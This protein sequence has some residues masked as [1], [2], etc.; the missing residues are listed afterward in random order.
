MNMPLN[1]LLSFFYKNY[2]YIF[3]F[4]CLNS[5]LF[6]QVKE[7]SVSDEGITWENSINKGY[8]KKSVAT[9]KKPGFA[10]KSTM[11]S[12][13]ILLKINDSIYQT[14]HVLFLIPSTNVV[15]WPDYQ[16]IFGDDNN[17]FGNKK[18][19][20]Y[21][22]PILK[23]LIPFNF[24]AVVLISD[25]ASPNYVPNY[26]FR[27]LKA[28]GINQNA[29]NYDD[30][31][32]CRYNIGGKRTNNVSINVLD[33]EMGHGWGVF[34]YPN[35]VGHWPYNSTV[36]CSMSDHW[37]DTR[38][39][40]IIPKGDPVNGFFWKEIRF[41]Q[42]I[43]FSLQQ[44]YLMGLQPD[45]PVAYLIN[46]PIF[47]PDSSISYTSYEKLDYNLII[48]NYGPRIPDYRTSQKKL[49]VGFIFV[50]PNLQAIEERYSDLE[51]EIIYY[52]YATE[53]ENN[54]FSSYYHETVP[55]NV[56]THNRASIDSKLADLDGNNSP[57]IF[58]PE[59][60]IKI[61]PGESAKI[62]FIASDIEDGM[63]EITCLPSDG[64]VTIGTSSLIFNSGSAE[65]TF[66]YT[67]KATDSGGKVC[68]EHFVVDVKPC[69]HTLNTLERS[70]I[71]GD[72]ILLG[73][74][75]RKNEGTYYDYY[76]TE[77]GCDSIIATELTIKPY[78]GILANFPLSS[79]GNDVTGINDPMTIT[80]A[81]FQEEGIY[82]NGIYTE[83]IAITPPIHEFDF[84]SFTIS[85]DFMVNENRQQ[86]VI[87]G[88]SG[89]RWLGFYLNADGTVSLLYN[90]NYYLQSTKTYTLN[91]WHNAQISYD[92]TTAKMYI[93]SM[94]AC[95]VNIQLDYAACGSS[96]T[97]IGIINSSNGQVFKGYIKNL[98]VYNT[99]IS[100]FLYLSRNKLNITS[101]KNNVD[102]FDIIS[103]TNWN[104]A[105][106]QPWLTFSNKTGM[107]NETISVYAITN[108][109]INPRFA[110]INVSGDEFVQKAIIVEQ[111]GT[112]PE[113]NVSP[114][115]ISVESSSGNVSITITSNVDWSFS[116]S[117]N[118]LQASKTNDSTLS[119][120]YDENTSTDIRSAI[121]T[122]IASDVL[123]H[124]A[125]IKQN[126]ADAV[127]NIR[128]DSQTVASSGGIT[129]FI[130]RSNINWTATENSDWLTVNKT[131]DS[132]LQVTYDENTGIVTRYTEITILGTGIS[133]QV[134]KVIQD[135]TT[136][137]AIVDVF[138]NSILTIY[139]NPAYSKI[140]IKPN[141]E[142]NK[143]IRIS[144]YDKTGKII[145]S[146]KINKLFANVPVEIDVSD[147][148]SGVYI[149]HISSDSTNNYKKI[150][151]K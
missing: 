59:K 115:N 81:P 148:P 15:K 119:V 29:I 110:T 140:Y 141:S 30:I 132:T 36:D 77:E 37:D 49:K 38:G 121:V 79:N 8:S 94:L 31:D 145:Y 73:G 17:A 130:I 144:L 98:K 22:I 19:D 21:Y 3:L 66:F 118:W 126:G 48:E 69:E 14:E 136:V 63:P 11:N 114:E 16:S 111:E 60:Y 112:I 42:R 102:T 149:L 45:F 12:E 104:I 47:N 84:N 103:N 5:S 40:E 10:L 86:P 52:S 142:I 43:E 101:S 135:G 123:T 23:N 7:S 74:K 91:K 147:L 20:S 44:L 105:S 82:C 107:N 24:D 85:A 116:E 137:N 1:K 35:D 70:I 67:I 128:P 125:I 4:S 27:K 122:L 32:I 99:F 53:K 50:A 34:V 58:L 6:S 113:L 39:S 139:P 129:K 18:F 134:V 9:L 131:N 120:T 143:K 109:S 96:D 41:R 33:H 51:K 133:S 13:P 80:N 92:G 54:V 90:N 26:C 64:M 108:P 55:F 61:I 124:D 76:R 46:E 106:D 97:Q 75:Y 62:S 146:Y 25:S 2:L 72:S 117:S 88:G 138:E 89:C 71:L 65:G 93:D 83:C 95:S 87:V 127:L 28:I 56:G 150:V 100:D 78:K 68:L 57:L 151:K